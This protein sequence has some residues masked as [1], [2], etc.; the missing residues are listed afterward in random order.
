MAKRKPTPLAAALLAVDQLSS[1]EILTLADYLRSKTA[2]PR[3]KAMKKVD[4]PSLTEVVKPQ[5]TAA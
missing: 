1:E 5:G 4:Q 3:K 2:T